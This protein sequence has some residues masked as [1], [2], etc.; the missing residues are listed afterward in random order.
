MSVVVFSE[1]VKDCL[2]DWYGEFNVSPVKGSLHTYRVDE[3]FTVRV[4]SPESLT[5]FT[6]RVL[7]PDRAWS[8]NLLDTLVDTAEKEFPHM[9]KRT[10]VQ[11]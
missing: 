1:F 10:L 8:G 7:G 6:S 9:R 3:C 4:D 2:E 11:F 5:L